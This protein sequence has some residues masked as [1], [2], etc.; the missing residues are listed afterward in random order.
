MIAKRN[1]KYKHFF[2]D[3]FGTVMFRK[4]SGD[5]IK[6]IWCKRLSAY[7]GFKVSEIE[8]YHLRTES[9][10]RLCRNL[11]KEFRYEDL[12]WKMYETLKSQ[13]LCTDE[14]AL[15]FTT[16]AKKTECEIE[17]HFQVINESVIEIVKDAKKQGKS[18]YILSD[19]YMGKQ[20]ISRFLEQKGVFD[21]FDDIFVSCD[22]M[23]NKVSG[24]LFNEIINRM[25]L[26][27]DECIMYGDNIRSDFLNAKRNNI[28]AHW[29]FNL[30]NNKAINSKDA[31]SQLL[32][33]STTNALSY[34]NYSF[35]F[36]RF[37][38][39]LYED[40]IKQQAKTVY[41]FSRE[42]ELLK[43]LFDRYS[44]YLSERFGHRK[45]ESK[46]L[47]VSRQSTYPASLGDINSEKFYGLFDLYT[48]ISVAAFLKS[49]GFDNDKIHILESNLDIDFGKVITDFPHSVEFDKLKDLPLF[50]D[51]YNQTVEVSRNALVSYLQQEGFCNN[52]KIFVVDVG[53]R[54]SIQSNIVNAFKN[55]V[56]IIGYYC[57]LS[58][59]INY[60]KK[61]LLFD[62]NDEKKANSIWG[63]NAT[64]MERVL[65][66]SHPSTKGYVCD[67][68][69]W[70]PVFNVFE[71]E[72]ENYEL[73][74]PIQDIMK[75]QFSKLMAID[76]YLP[77]NHKEMDTLFE[78]FHIYTCC[79]V[80]KDNM[81][82]LQSLLKGQMENFG[83][84]TTAGLNFKRL[85]TF[86]RIIKKILYNLRFL[87]D[88]NLIS[89]ALN[90]KGCYR[91]A[92]LIYR[93][94]GV[95]LLKFV[96]K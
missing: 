83:F 64:F 13:N 5:D 26:K 19:F 81:K 77:A 91:A 90:I 92:A 27:K 35:C 28:S 3:F 67:T 2:F 15:S 95:S 57:G 32:I 52:E 39:L 1:L 4:C 70:L 47:Y 30:G 56:N 69:K 34:A 36:Y 29:I 49:I 22:F 46:Y 54:G 51:F 12:L 55:K 61:G 9:E 60:T 7:L 50:S 42:G 17:E 86:K 21:L 89:L 8:L 63:Y 23:C 84:Q 16:F 88:L 59:S 33:R 68:E 87:F 96:S 41:F 10:Q 73:I 53:W 14:Q 37:I 43:E 78:R 31:L 24:E 71:T 58:A 6:R 65:T 82:L 38:K 94:Q 11:H 85:F 45:I 48:E 66:A 25:H 72:K 20:T 79:H 74:K 40:L 93:I 44:S 80:G 18:V 75:L 76:W 62:E